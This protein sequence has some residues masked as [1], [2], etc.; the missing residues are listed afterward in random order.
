MFCKPCR[1]R[2]KQLF[3]KID[4]TLLKNVDLAL[5]VTQKL[6]T[7]L[8]SATAV[9]LTKLIPGDIDDSIR[10]LL[11][12]A[13]ENAL[14]KSNLIEPGQQVV[15][16]VSTIPRKHNTDSKLHKAAS[17]ITRSLDDAR[18]PDHIYDL[19]VQASYSMKKMS[20]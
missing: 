14:E 15:T 4:E 3:Q 9:S 8:N 12:S 7:A 2:I 20:D 13:I 18:H 11:L 1:N 6:K 19:A 16:Y 10:L 5:S 17:L